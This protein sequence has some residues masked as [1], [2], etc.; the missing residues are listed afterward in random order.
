MTRR[1]L[2][3]ML[4]LTLTLAVA[5]A[6]GGD[7]DAAGEPASGTRDVTLILNWTPNAHHLGV[8]AAKEKGWYADEAIDLKIVEPAQS[9]AAEQ[10]VGTGKAQFGISQAE[11]VVPA[12]A[13]GV[14]IVSV[15]TLL[16]VNDSALMSLAGEGIT[17]PEALAGR[18][19]GGYGGSL[20]TELIDRLAACAGMDPAD[21]PRVEVGNIDYLAGLEADRFDF[22]WIFAGWDALRASE[23][24]GVD[25]DLIRFA[26][27]FDC[28]PNWYTP[29]VVTNEETIEQDPQLVRDFLAVTTRGYELATEDP[30]EAARLMLEAVPEADEDLLRAAADYYA[31][32]FAPDGARFGEQDRDT[33]DAFARFLAEA[34]LVEREID[35]DEAFTNELLPR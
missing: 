22:V 29:L 6:C 7:D 15:A 35:V 14:P 10:S 18:R 30:Q 20:E 24:E 4:A 21:V 9:G 25:V 26:D 17:G 13:E 12:R 28:I 2:P 33:W 3:V 11:S 27:H 32:R 5:S 34:G 31:T 23:I 8:Y 16:P 1:S 19:Y